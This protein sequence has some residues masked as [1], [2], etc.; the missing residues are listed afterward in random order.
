MTA[1]GVVLPEQSV[2]ECRYC[3]APVAAVRLRFYMRDGR[4]LKV[5]EAWSGRGHDCPKLKT[6]LAP[7]IE[8]DGEEDIFSV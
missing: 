1:L 5:G 8:F 3:S 6:T 2:D 4:G 7:L